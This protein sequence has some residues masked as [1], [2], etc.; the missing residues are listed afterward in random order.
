M[1]IRHRRR[2]A[3]YPAMNAI[4]NAIREA[5]GEGNPSASA[6]RGTGAASRGR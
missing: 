6:D 2:P 3:D 4:A 1:T 5:Q